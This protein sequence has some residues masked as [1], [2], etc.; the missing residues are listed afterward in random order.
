MSRWRGSVALR[1]NR[2]LKGMHEMKLAEKSVPTSQVAMGKYPINVT[3]EGLL[4][5]RSLI[6]RAGS[7]LVASVAYVLATA[8]RA[9][10]NHCGIYYHAG[11]CCLATP[12]GGCPGS[13]P[14]HTCP[15][16]YQKRQWTCCDFSGSNLRRCS[17]CTTGAT[18]FEGS[19]VCSETWTAPPPCYG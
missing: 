15:D 4:N 19:F 12:P 5:R 16:G 8:A 6:T 7:A 14:T 17:E 10:A 11:C 1:P 2:Q 13:G 3:S 18:C 9:E